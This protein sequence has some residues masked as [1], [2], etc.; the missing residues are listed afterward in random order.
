MPSNHC[1]ILSLVLGVRA[2]L[3]GVS[4]CQD[5][6]SFWAPP[7][8]PAHAAGCRSSSGRLWL[9]MKSSDAWFQTEIYCTCKG[10]QTLLWTQVLCRPGHFLSRCGNSHHDFKYHKTVQTYLDKK[11][12]AVWH[13]ENLTCLITTESVQW[14]RV[15][16]SSKTADVISLDSK[17]SYRDETGNTVSDAVDQRRDSHLSS[18]TRGAHICPLCHTFSCLRLHATGS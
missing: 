2:G 10:K 9:V 15:R 17:Y 7:L 12:N 13:K 14:L 16:G 18:W 6:I 3:D 4:I 5:P 8:N 11:C 1:T